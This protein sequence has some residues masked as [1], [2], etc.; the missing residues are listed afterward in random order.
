MNFNFD[1]MGITLDNVKEFEAAFADY[2]K[3]LREAGKKAVAIDK[4]TAT[5]LA[6]LKIRE[7]EI[8]KGASVVVMYNGA[9]VVGTVKNT[10]TVEAKN[11]PVLSDSFNNKDKFLYVIKSAFVRMA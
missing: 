2:K 6:N 11:I 3:A 7:G 9:E 4:Q 10:P 5:D 1:A 8:T